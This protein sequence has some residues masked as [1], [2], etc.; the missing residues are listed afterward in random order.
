MLK[1]RQNVSYT[2]F[3]QI[4]AAIIENYL[5]W[6]ISAKCA[7]KYVHKIFIPIFWW[8]NITVELILIC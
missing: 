7:C 4:S 1:S 8:S 3:M 6:Y 5:L 2:F